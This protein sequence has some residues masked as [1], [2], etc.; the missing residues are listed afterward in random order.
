MSEVVFMTPEDARYGFSLAGSLQLTVQAEQAEA[1]LR[2]TMAD[3]DVGVVVIDERLVK[4]I[5][6]KQFAELEAN[7][8]GLLVTLPAPEQEA[9]GE[10]D[11]LQ[12]LIRRA[13][14][15]HVRLQL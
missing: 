14:G 13:L 12:R 4:A 9:E 8:A 3:K 7:W 15:Y 2:E 6:E 11:Y 1:Q 10:E 5:D